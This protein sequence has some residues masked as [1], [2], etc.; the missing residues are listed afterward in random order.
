MPARH[1]GPGIS[2]KTTADAGT[3]VQGARRAGS[4][5]DEAA[6]HH[7]REHRDVGR[8]LDQ[9]ITDVTAAS[10]M[11]RAPIV[12]W[13]TGPSVSSLWRFQEV[14]FQTSRIDHPGG[15]TT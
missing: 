3:P 12:A 10:T 7:Q 6:P 14:H 9:D 11:S 5:G 13:I 8:A 1:I 2:R 15:R 4:G